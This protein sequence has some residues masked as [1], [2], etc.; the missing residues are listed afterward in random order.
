[1]F[2]TDLE[3]SVRSDLSSLDGVAEC[4]LMQYLSQYPEWILQAA[5]DH[6][7]QQVVNYLLGLA[8]FFHIYY[9]QVK[10]I[11]ILDSTVRHAHFSLCIAIANVISNALSVLGIVAIFKM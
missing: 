6:E 10:L 5:K 3:E 9:D 4:D 2:F 8:R 1:M 11:K 7:P